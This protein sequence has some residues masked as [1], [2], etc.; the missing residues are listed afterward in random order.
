[1]SR[2]LALTCV[3]A[4][5][6]TV[7]K[8]AGFSDVKRLIGDR[9]LSGA[10]W[11]RDAQADGEIA[12]RVDTLL[13]GE[14]TLPVALQ[15]AL[16]FSPR[17]QATFERLGVAQAEVV[18]AGL[19]RNPSFGVHLG[20]PFGSPPGSA[21]AW[22]FSLFQ[23]ILDLFMLP[24]K[25]K[26]ARAKFER[27]K[28][29]VADQ[30]LEL[31]AEVRAAWFTALSSQQ[32]LQLRRT[33]L[34][35]Q[36]ASAE[37]AARQEEAGTLSE[38]DLTSEQGLYAQARL[39]V[40]RSEQQLRADRERL[41]RLLGLWGRRTA[42]KLPEKLPDLPP[43]ASE[44]R[45]ETLESFAI[46]HRLDIAAARA[47]VE[48][49][50]RALSLTKAVRWIGSLEL[51]G[52]THR[53]PEGTGIAGPSLR[54]EIPIFDQG[55]ARVARLVAEWRAA[56]RNLEARAVELRSHVRELRGRL[57]TQRAAVEYLRTRVLPLRE[58]TV[59][60]AHE[61]YNVM[62]L[63]TYQLIAAKQREIDAWRDYIETVR[64]YW[65]ARSDLERALGAPIPQGD[66]K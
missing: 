13:S 56:R 37:L 58:R 47:H 30:V 3:L 36:E 49:A 18:Q 38:L 6:C 65:I 45:S 26:L 54:L 27:V 55:Q 17:L 63:G 9:G 64:D 14:L 2:T 66:G 43:E 28:L 22:E 12:R 10:E 40:L 24:L 21:L 44:P 32:V 5:A 19:L 60:L 61:Q 39:D 4:S 11:R 31:A 46:S 25:K 41:T 20:L 15:I 57:Y 51:G 42:Y 53:E 52:D 7:P 48:S 62:L 59:A 29:E 33:I 8:D 16:S 50:R 1:M 23:E 35:A 34:E